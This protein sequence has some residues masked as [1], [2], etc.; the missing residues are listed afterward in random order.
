VPSFAFSVVDADGRRIRGREDAQTS[1]LLL[2]N[3]EQRGWLVLDIQEPDVHVGYAFVFG[4]RNAVLEMTRGLAALLHAGMPLTRALNTVEHVSHASM[5]GVILDVREAVERG[6]P[7]ASAFGG[8]PSHFSPHFVG[9]VRAGERSGEL[10]SAMRRLAD[11]LE[12]DHALRS[13]IISVSIYPMLLAVLGSGAVVVLLTLVLPRF[14]E[15][16][17]GAGAT[18]PHSTQVLLSAS[19]AFQR[20]WPALL[21]IG[22]GLACTVA[23]CQ[24][25]TSGRRVAAR[26]LLILPVVST[27]RREILAARFARLTGTLATSGTPLL[28]ALHDTIECVDD[29]LLRDAVARAHALVR[30]GAS[31]SRAI[32][33]TRL[34]PA[35]LPQLVEI[36]EESGQL[37][38]FLLK[39]AE[40]FEG[41][42]ERTT[43]RLVTLL[44]PAM[45]LTFGSIVA[46]V[47]LSLLQAIYGI[48]ASAF[49]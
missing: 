47:A 42:V 43:Q 30:D 25:S 41:R 19:T 22:L 44:E 37:H 12:H 35:L 28:S 24:G 45:I 36:G 46:I 39:A 14:A 31:L 32:A 20:F 23:W 15:L 18:L 17:Q 3:L 1:A 21:T 4:R 48:N 49:R 5:R 8:H 10:S 2:R 16:L 40:L 26:L 27:I 13:R 34:F 33:D 9:L 38:E 7:L 29:P 11:Q 6:T